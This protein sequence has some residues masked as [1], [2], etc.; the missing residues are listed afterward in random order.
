M[1][2]VIRDNER[3]YAIDLISHINT[4]AQQY[5]LQIKKAGGE[6]TISTGRNNRMFPDVVLYGDIARTKILQG[7]E[8]KLPDT[9][10]T[11]EVFIKDAQRKAISLGLNSCFI[12]NFTA[13]VLYIK[14]RA[15]VFQIAKQWNATSHIR[16][17]PDVATYRTDWEQAIKEIIL[18]LN[19]YFVSGEIT[20]ASLGEVI[21]DSVIAT[22][23]RRNKSLVADELRTRCTSNAVMGAT[24]D[25]WWSEVSADFAAD[26]PDRYSA[27]A[28]I[29]V[30]NW[31]NRIVFAHLIKRHHNAASRVENIIFDMSPEDANTIFAGI[32]AE[33][34]F[35]NIFSSVDFNQYLPQDTWSD[36]NEL[37]QF[38]IE[39]GIDEIEQT[40]LQTILE[41]SV[42]TAKR[43]LA[44]QFTTPTKL[45]EL[46]GKITIL[47]W[48]KPC[49]DP[50][51]GTGSIPQAILNHKK[52]IFDITA[53]VQ[54]TWASDKYAYPLHVET[55]VLMSRVEK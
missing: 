53:A 13:G 54:S 16:S 40:T 20:S 25:V 1:P 42:S 5:T 50:C 30:L 29:I 26:E 47:D 28:K 11:D 22:T 3:S 7:W 43:E 2:T 21:S 19:Q 49:L 15:G 35:F 17:R 46:L 38:L 44:G 27:Y 51:C 8:L 14:D 23:I 45:A 36:L 4:L 24:I 52:T 55:V 31:T 10:I 48:N 18:E 6:R 34:D 12:W 39:N 41:N 37:N 32:S 9:L 33:C